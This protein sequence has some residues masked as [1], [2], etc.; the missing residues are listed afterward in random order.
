MSFATSFSATSSRAASTTL[1]PAA[2]KAL[3]PAAPIPR[4]A[5]VTITT[6]FAIVSM[7]P[8]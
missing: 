2:A 8:G 7:T 4:L 6:L 1:A 5:P 3:A